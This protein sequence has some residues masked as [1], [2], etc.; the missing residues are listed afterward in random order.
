MSPQKT[1][2]TSVQTRIE[3]SL[4]VL[5]PAE[6]I[7]RRVQ[8]LALEISRG[9]ADKNL[10]LLVVLKGAFVF[11]ADL[12]RSLEIPSEVEFIC[13]R[14]YV[15]GTVSSGNVRTSFEP[16]TL[17]GRDVLIV[18]D[19]VDTGLTLSEVRQCLIGLGAA[20]VRICALL[21]KPSRRKVELNVDYVGFVIPNIFV[22]GYGIDIDETHRG[23]SDLHI[24]D[25]DIEASVCE[26]G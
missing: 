24:Y 2:S 16:E 18:E 11:A 13:A 19:I 4:P 5:V 14:S 9:Y 3:Q 6:K 23:L 8:E 15:K 1:S 12:L 21:D 20:S 22:V 26:V 17:A 7:K 10:T 25:A